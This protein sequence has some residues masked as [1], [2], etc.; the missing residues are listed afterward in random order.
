MSALRRGFVSCTWTNSSLPSGSSGST[1]SASCFNNQSRSPSIR[2]F[3]TSART[4]ARV[5]EDDFYKILEIGQGANQKDIKQQFYKLSKQWHPDVNQGSEESK[6]KFQQVSEA[7]ATL[8]NESSRK[9]YDR[10]R[11]ST[12]FGARRGGGGAGMRYDS[13]NLQRRA[14][15]SYAWDYQRRNAARAFKKANASSQS[16]SGQRAGM[17]SDSTYRTHYQHD[18]NSAAE[19]RSMFERLAEQQRKREAAMQARYEEQNSGGDGRTRRGD[20]ASSMYDQS[21]QT[22]SHLVR[23]MQVT[24]LFGFIFYC[25]TFLSDGGTNGPVA[26]RKRVITAGSSS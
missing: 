10:Q 2:Q 24:G 23:F 17:G 16:A 26:T 18:G 8:G 7:Y 11:S 21:G 14:T 25:S 6:V 19:D 3:R 1:I 22:S 5:G 9:Q 20:A 15:A 4:N 12:G 13:D